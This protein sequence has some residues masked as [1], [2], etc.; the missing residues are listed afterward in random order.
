MYEEE[1]EQLVAKDFKS[2]ENSQTSMDLA[3]TI[4]LAS[5]PLIL[6]VMSTYSFNTINLMF[7]GKYNEPELLSAVG[8]GTT[9][10][11]TFGMGLSIGLAIGLNVYASHAYGARNFHRLG[12]LYQKCMVINVIP[13]LIMA[14]S[15]LIIEPA[16]VHFNFDHQFA[17]DV[18]IFTQA[19][20][21]C[22]I[23]Y[24]LFYSTVYFLMAQRT[25][26]IGLILSFPAACIHPLWCYLFIDVMQFKVTGAALALGA[27]YWLMTLA[28]FI[29]C[30]Y[31]Y[32]NQQVWIPWTRDC[33]DDIG[34]FIVDLSS[35][36][37]TVYLGWIF[38][39]I[40]TI[41]IAF[42]ND[43][44]IMAGHVAALNFFYMITIP[45]L[46]ISTSAASLLGN[47]AGEGNTK[48]CLHISKV[49]TWINGIISTILVIF[50]GIYSDLIAQIYTTE[51]NVGPITSDIILIYL[52]GF[53]ADIYSDQLAFQ[54]RALDQSAFVFK[55]F[56]LSNYGLGIIAA[57]LFTFFFDMSYTGIWMAMN[58]SFWVNGL[59]YVWKLM[60]IDWD[61]IIQYISKNMKGSTSNST[62]EEEE[63]DDD[64]DE[65]EDVLTL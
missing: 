56:V 60:R 13:I 9:W 23:G 47:A 11:I 58:L 63:E 41:M 50:M 37:I 38:F 35:V 61:K 64:D 30:K 36:G 25:F 45:N 21:P 44:N 39:E 2:N 26:Y 49:T 40:N 48:L 14:A 42:L 53:H 29:Y 8:F 51:E 57:L 16:L 6:T 54:L 7:L 55:S 34:S 52:I 3:K 12:L 4:I 10:L 18:R 59:S 33:L 31:W 62:R 46:E 17:R 43:M 32:K 28:I 19:S 15:T 24:A 1:S 65:E 5:I 22:L 27:S 20:L